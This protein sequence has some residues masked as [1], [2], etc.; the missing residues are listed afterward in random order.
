MVEAEHVI[1]FERSASAETFEP[2]T[3]KFSYEEM[4][5]SSRTITQHRADGSLEGTKTEDVTQVVE[6]KVTLIVFTGK[7]ASGEDCEHFFDAFDK[8]QN[9]LSDVWK[10]ESKSKTTDATTLFKAMAKMLAGQPLVDWNNVLED[11]TSSDFETFKT[12][13]S[14]FIVKHVLK[15]EKGYDIQVEYMTHRKLP[16][17]M[18][19]DTWYNRLLTMNR[20][21]C[22]FFEDMEDMKRTFSGAAFPNW[23]NYGPLD[24]NALRRVAIFN[25]PH[26]FMEEV[27]RVDV[28]RT[29]RDGPI[30]KLIGY[31]LDLQKTEQR[32]AHLRPADR[33]AGARQHG[34]RG[35][36]RGAGRFQ[37]QQQQQY[38]REYPRREWR[39]GRGP[40][41]PRQEGPA[42]PNRNNNTVRGREW[43]NDRRVRRNDNNNYYS[44]RENNNYGRG[45][46]QI[47]QQR[48][49][50]RG[51]RYNNN[52]RNNN[53]AGVQ[54]QGRGR[55]AFGRGGH[56]YYQEHGGDDDENANAATDAVDASD[57]QFAIDEDEL[58]N[59]WND[60]L[61]FQEGV[62]DAYYG[63]YDDANDA[64]YDYDDAYYDGD[65]NRYL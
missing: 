24:T 29:L 54:R 58:I 16:R 27:K 17:G 60:N 41:W 34:N 14:K 56:M 55:G 40:G 28:S 47:D 4:K 22:Y 6:Q 49:F 38:Y 23:W 57:E 21:L 8:M 7:S 61:F 59:Q 35:R 15:T 52:N 18:P 43:A 64:E 12:A 32:K 11:Y 2:T 3:T 5:E 45:R 26:T 50:G 30:D 10:T 9:E 44:G 39:S 53:Q 51:G 33:I 37:H 65:D 62:N 36:G 25:V 63:E 46:Q 19:A 1:P 48:N 13:V 42:W 31:Y 20:Y